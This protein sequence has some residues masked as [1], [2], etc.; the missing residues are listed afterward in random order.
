MRGRTF[1]GLGAVLVSALCGCSSDN[2][3]PGS[4][5]SQE[6]GGTGGAGGEGGA[7]AL[8]ISGGGAG[9]GGSGGAGGTGGTGGA[10]SAGETHAGTSAGG[11]TN[12]AGSSA[13]G[14][15][16]S[17]PAGMCKRSAGS[18]ADCV[19][20]YPAGDGDAAKS[21]AYAC[22]DT[23]AFVTLSGAHGGK[24]ASASFVSGAKYG[25]C[26]PP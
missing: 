21:Q 1:L 15:G 13:G 5:I 4:T 2:T 26:C 14:S 8:G 12:H 19:D 7:L 6:K 20:F 16:G 18:D 25:A 24:C 23:S 9:G 11:T 10:G 22:D 17:K 3:G